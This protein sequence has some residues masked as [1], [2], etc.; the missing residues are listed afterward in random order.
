MTD[1]Q[2]I[3]DTRRWV[4]EAVI[5][6]NLCPFAKAVQVKQ[7]VH[8]TVSRARDAQQLSKDLARELIALADMPPQQRDTTLLIVPDMLQDFLDFNDFLDQADALLEQLG[9]SGILQ[10]ADFHPDYQFAD[11]QPEDPGNY[12]N[13]APYP[14]LHLLREDSI[15]AAVA[16]FPDASAIFE[17]NIEVLEALGSQGLAKVGFPFRGNGHEEKA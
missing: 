15:D 7:L 17:R 11:T 6:L 10:I 13:R 5:G 12:T 9:F 8:Y 4:D 2:L 16:A 3:N 1:E 14:T